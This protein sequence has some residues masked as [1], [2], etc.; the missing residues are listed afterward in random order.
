[1]TTSHF[2]L[3]FRGYS[4]NYLTESLHGIFLVDVGSLGL[5]LEAE[6]S[7]LVKPEVRGELGCMEL[8]GILYFQKYPNL[9][10]R[11]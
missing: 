2:L 9:L 1:M 8:T 11:I 3:Y 10:L 5:E 4:S 7:V 6:M